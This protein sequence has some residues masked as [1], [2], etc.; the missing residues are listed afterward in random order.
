MVCAGRKIA[1]LCCA[2]VI[3]SGVSFGCRRRPAETTPDAASVA[4]E[5]IRNTLD[6]LFAYVKISRADK[7]CAYCENEQEAS[8]YLSGIRENVGEAVLE[9]VC[10]RVGM[11]I[12]DVDADE[13]SGRARVKVSGVDGDGVVSEA[14]GMGGF[15]SSSELQKA[16]DAVG[17]VE[18]ELT[19]DLLFSDS[20]KLRS[21]SADM[22]LKELFG[23]LEYD[24]LIA[25]PEETSHEPKKLDISVYDSY[26]VNTGGREVGGYHCSADKV[27]LYVY[28]WN[29]YSNV[30]I[31][32]EFVDESGAVLYTNVF[33]MKN[34]TDWIACSWRPSADLAEGELRCRVY[35]PTGE[36]FHT[37][38]VRIFPDGVILPFPVTWMDACFWADEAGVKVDFYP[39]DAPLLEYHA[40]SLR[41]YEDLYLKYRFLDEDGN[42]LYQGDL[43]VTDLTDTF[44]FSWDR[45]GEEALPVK[46]VEPSES[47][48]APDG[49]DATGGSSGVGEPADGSTGTTG[50]ATAT[51]ASGSA[52]G[53]GTT[54]TMTPSEPTEPPE[55]TY[56]FLEVTTSDGQP[57]LETQVEIRAAGPEAVEETEPSES[58]SA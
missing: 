27:C 54:D 25:E 9:A 8:S 14:A 21:E 39:A 32:Y 10:R 58:T 12:L 41:H 49:G 5:R 2:I 20:W 13:K 45:E 4:A 22:L 57:F 28:T 38:A 43:E 56:V 48:G 44:V 51:T 7:V 34:N 37:S 47:S 16:I 50:S 6:D 3:L 53:S 17:S 36:L 15:P 19:L 52:A 24:G 30:D 33:S 18:K 1:S 46:G 35:E 42:V 26:W 11:T 23:F 55:P 29:T 31:R 40:Q